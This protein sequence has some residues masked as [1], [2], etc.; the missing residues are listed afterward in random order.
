VIRPHVH[1]VSRIQSVCSAAGHPLVTSARFAERLGGSE[2][3][4][5]GHHAL[6]GFAEPLELHTFARRN[7]DSVD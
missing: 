6:T 1:L 3:I 7:A 4:S 5:I 2:T